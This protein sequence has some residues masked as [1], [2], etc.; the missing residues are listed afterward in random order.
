MSGRVLESS[1]FSMIGLKSGISVQYYTPPGPNCSSFFTDWDCGWLL[2]SL[3][4]ARKRLLSR[5]A[6]VN[7]VLEDLRLLRP[8]YDTK[9]KMILAY[10]KLHGLAQALYPPGE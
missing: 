3:Y 8:E 9:E 10:L 4:D 1:G 5:D 7:G 2:F 6:A